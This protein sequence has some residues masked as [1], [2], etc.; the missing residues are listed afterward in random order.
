[1]SFLNEPLSH[2]RQRRIVVAPWS[3]PIFL[4]VEAGFRS[5]LV[6]G[7]AWRHHAIVKEEE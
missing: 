6:P 2:V 7:S 1:M 3:H 4:G 5:R